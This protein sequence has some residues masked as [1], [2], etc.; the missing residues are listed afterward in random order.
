MKRIIAM[1]L[2]ILALTWL[3]SPVMGG[4]QMTV[5]VVGASG[6]TG[7]HAVSELL[8]AGVEVRAMTR[9]AARAK[10][11]VAAD[12]PWVQGDVSDRESL[13]SAFAGVTHVLAAMGSSAR[14]PSNTPES[15]DYMGVVNLTDAARAAGVDRLVL[16][17]SMGVT[18]TEQIESDHMK[19]L[20]SQK[21]KGEDYLRASGVEFTVVRPGGLNTADAFQGALVIGQ[22]DEGSFGTLSRADL[23][24]V[25]VECL[26]NQH[27]LNKTFE[28]SGSTEGD[29]EAWRES[30]KSLR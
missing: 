10:R 27:T 19:N 8:E 9:N 18:R 17:S 15:V 16:I 20:L 28:I 22:G 7:R 30:L 6:R 2:P 14:D 23:A 21:L 1:F 29:P 5:L 4:D 3:P 12:Y 13:D 26:T 24:R 11:D 25:S